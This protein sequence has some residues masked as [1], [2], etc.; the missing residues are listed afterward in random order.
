M[1][2]GLAGFSCLSCREERWVVGDIRGEKRGGVAYGLNMIL[3]ERITEKSG[4][5]LKRPG[6]V[7]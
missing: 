5:E 6:L 4:C 1:R 3:E 2:R 7:I